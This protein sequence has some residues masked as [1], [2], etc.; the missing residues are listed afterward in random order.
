MTGALFH[1]QVAEE[2]K[3]LA[4]ANRRI[5]VLEQDSIRLSGLLTEAKGEATRLASTLEQ[6]EADK[7]DVA[8]RLAAAQ[9]IVST[10]AQHEQAALEMEA[11]A[12]GAEQ[13]L[14]SA[15]ATL[16]TQRAQIKGL[17][18]D[19]TQLAQRNSVL[20]QEIGPIRNLVAALSEKQ[21]AERRIWEELDRLE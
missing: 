11:R 2:Q 21:A 4:E 19:K 15:Q 10:A 3:R 13:D 5:S 16:E 12:A 17:N 7:A 1:E 20:E 6:A 9:A 18:S 14:V 8:R